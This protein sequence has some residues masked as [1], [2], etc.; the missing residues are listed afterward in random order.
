MMP[1]EQYAYVQPDLAAL[2]AQAA[3]LLAQFESATTADEQIDLLLKINQFQGSIDTHFTLANVR[4]SIDTRDEFYDKAVNFLTEIGPSIEEFNQRFKQAFLNSKFRPALVKRFG[5]LFFDQLSLS[6]KTFHPS[7]KDDLVEESK[8]V[9]EYDALI[10]SAKIPFDG[11]EL[12]LA[13]LGKYQ[14]SL[15]RSVRKA[16]SEAYWGFFAERREKFD[17]LYDSLVQVRTRIAKKL[18]Y[19]NFVQLGYDRLGRLDYNAKDVAAYRQQVQESLVPIARRL[20]KEQSERIGI[21]NMFYY[22]TPLQ[23]L[24][25]NPT[26]KGDRA[27]MEEL[28]SQMY[29]ELAPETD[30]FFT[31]MRKEHLLDLDNKPGKMAGGYM[32][33]IYD[34]KVPFIFANFNGTKHDVEVLTHE[35]GHALQGYLCKDMEI[36]EYMSPT[37]EACE[38]HSMSM[39]FFTYPWMDLF[40]KEDTPKFKYSHIADALTFIP[41]GVTVDEFQHFVY[42]NPEATPEQ[43]RA[44]WRE[45]EQKYTPYKNYGDNQFLQDGGYWMRQGHIFAAPFYYIDYTL[46]QVLAMQYFVKS[47]D[48]FKAAWKNYLELCKLGGSLPFKAL[49]KNVG[50]QLPFEAGTIA[51]LVPTL[52]KELS[53]IDPK[54]L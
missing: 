27:W 2:Q 20:M 14:Q 3:N 21:S 33:F 9:L 41:Y 28:A 35:V 47:Q 45:I 40:F 54:Q 5:S 8:L 24:T 39:E 38:I 13:G 36:R 4:H 6:V 48:D 11:K 31:L 29:R 46:A 32:T 1:F 23:F 17:Q 10:A 19:E 53:S 52:Q 25:G 15:D 49:V 12:N 16:A 43:R 7:I 44:K 37:L 30:A 50:L 42:E 51:G 22:D 26:P 34:Y 18:G